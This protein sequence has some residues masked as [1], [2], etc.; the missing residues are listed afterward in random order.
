MVQEKNNL[1]EINKNLENIQQAISYL[2]QKID[3]Q[4]AR[5]NKIENIDIRKEEVRQD[6]SSTSITAPPPPP[7]PEC[8][9]LTLLNY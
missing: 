2:S 7:V 3:S 1:E 8:P 6:F 4:E 5:I 9:V